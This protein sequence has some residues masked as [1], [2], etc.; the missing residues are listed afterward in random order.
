M[1][2]PAIPAVLLS[3]KPPHVERLMAGTKTVEL[4][5]RRWRVPPGTV[6]LVYASGT[7]RALVGSVVVGATEA[8]SPEDIWHSHGLASEITREEFDSYFAGAQEAIAI[9]IHSP[10]G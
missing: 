9:G 6:A 10:H 3:V 1:S 4:R 5:R 2:S 7:T 8:G